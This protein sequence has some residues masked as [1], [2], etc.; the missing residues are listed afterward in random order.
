MSLNK[1]SNERTLESIISY[2]TM[3]SCLSYENEHF[4]FWF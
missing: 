3:I 2:Q 4:D 1:S